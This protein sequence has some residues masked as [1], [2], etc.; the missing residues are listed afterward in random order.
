MARK[1][2]IKIKNKE[3]FSS[4]SG[5][6]SEVDVYSI[7]KKKDTEPPLEEFKFHYRNS[8]SVEFSDKYFMAHDID[9]AI[10]MF[11]YACV[12]RHL[13]T[14]VTQISKWNRWSSKWEKFDLSEYHSGKPGLNLCF[15]FEKPENRIKF[16]H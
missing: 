16:D 6:S 12:K 7:V 13:D 3:N 14:E 11:D 1:M 2:R 9:E 8:G 15:K 4:K 5:K 10:G